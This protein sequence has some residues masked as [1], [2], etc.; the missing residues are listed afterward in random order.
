M[1]E[2]KLQAEGY[3]ISTDKTL[4]DMEM[5]YNYLGGES[6]WAK[7][8]ARGVMEKAIDNAI[9]FGVYHQKKQVGFAKGIT[10]KATFAYLADVFILEQ[11]RGLGLSKWLMQTIRQ[12]TDLQGLRRFLLAT[13]DAHG[14]YAQFGF[15]PLSN[16]ERWMQIYTPYQTNN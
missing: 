7:G 2:N 13:A 9:C 11:Y 16:P 12:H 6:Y 8:M 10:N 4:L 15:E 1:D 5:M 3:H 14:L